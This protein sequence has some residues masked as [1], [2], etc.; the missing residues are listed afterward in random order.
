MPCP[1]HQEIE[2]PMLADLSG[3]IQVRLGQRVSGK[4]SIWYCEDSWQTQHFEKKAVAAA[5]VAIILRLHAHA[6]PFKVMQ[7]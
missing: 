3:I 2:T 1:H 4:P 6:H 5:S 7:S